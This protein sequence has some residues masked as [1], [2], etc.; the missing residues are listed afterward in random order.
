MNKTSR[1]GMH[2]VLAMLLCMLAP[3]AL[4]RTICVFSL[5]GA[6]GDL[7]EQMKGYQLAA[8]GWGTP[9]ELKVFTD[10]RVA[11]EDLKAGFCDGLMMTGIRAR[12][13]VPFTGSIDAIG[14]LDSYAGL[15]TLIELLAHPKLAE[16]QRHGAYETAGILPLGAAYLHINDRSINSVEK[17][18]GHTMAVFDN[19]RAQVLMA[20]HVG[21]RPDL[22]DVTNF[23]SK[24]NNGVV[25]VIAAPAVAY[26]PLELY[27][28]VGARG[29]V[30]KMP[31]AL[32]TQQLVLRHEKFAEDF[33]AR[34]RRYFADQFEPAMKVVHAAEK[35]ILFFFPP[36]DRD[37]ERY[38]QMMNESR[39]FLIESGV[40]DTA[41]MG[42]MK[43]VRCK[44]APE[45]AECG[46]G[47]AW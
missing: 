16:S 43:K 12:Q 37:R 45:R 27:R 17:I 30:L 47:R 34:S 22:S 29:V 19:D 14:G 24:F 18:A 36:P 21:M 35:E 9:I 42:W 25:D 6:Q 39:V 4:A 15:Q 44:V 46:D 3:A 41:M 1:A 40:Y 28:G 26:L 32:L 10:E 20:E 5:I 23:S 7:W 38:S 8:A 31:T 13:F 11:A 2:I 33:M